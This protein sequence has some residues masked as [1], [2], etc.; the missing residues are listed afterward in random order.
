MRDCRPLPSAWFPD[1]IIAAHHHM[2]I[3]MRPLAAAC[4]GTGLIG[5]SWALV[6]ARLHDRVW[7]FDA[8]SDAADEAQAYVHDA[9]NSMTAGAVGHTAELGDRV[10]VAKS[11][12]EAVAGASYIQE[13]V[14]ENLAVKRALAAEIDRLAPLDAI[15]ASST[16]EYR[17]TDIFAD[18]AGRHRCLV[19]H[20]LNP[21]HLVPAVE[22]CPAA[23][24]A[25]EVVARTLDLLRTAGQRPIVVRREVRG[26]VM[27]RLQ[28]AVL[29]E[30]LSLVQEQ[31]CSV[32][33]LDA[34]M[35]FGLARRWAALGPFETN[36]LATE[37]GYEHFL[38]A[39]GETLRSIADD[40]SRAWSFDAT[41]GREV[42]AQLKEMLHGEPR[43]E[44]E[45]R[46][47]RNLS[48][49]AGSGLEP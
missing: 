21:P 22:V 7:L 35:K 27:N 29:R 46:R 19:A 48:R 24:T 44:T 28:L 23:F 43:A 39:Y 10:R 33:D 12:R 47:D 1:A 2:G 13:S 30:A 40:L 9:M 32:A 49:I 15:L 6:L 16:S 45:A 14:S 25:P 17:P 26:F 37:K 36:Y 18:V 34:A 5:R 20:P 42:D 31:V 11:L 41:I 38:A 3:N 4:I 8:S